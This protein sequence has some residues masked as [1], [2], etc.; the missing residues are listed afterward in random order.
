MLVGCDEVSNCR[1]GKQVSWK[2]ALWKRAVP[3]RLCL[4]IRANTAGDHDDVSLIQ[5][6]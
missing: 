5:S 1:R 4:N 2:V 6:W 3:T